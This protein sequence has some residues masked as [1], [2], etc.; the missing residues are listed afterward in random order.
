MRI[1]I[2]RRKFKRGDRQTDLRGLSNFSVSMKR[3][4]TLIRVRITLVILD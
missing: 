3:R 1:G 2:E 4:A